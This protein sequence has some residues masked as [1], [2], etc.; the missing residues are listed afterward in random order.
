MPACIKIRKQTATTPFFVGQILNPKIIFFL[1]R[2]EYNFIR[3]KLTLSLFDFVF[4]RKY[5]N[6]YNIA[7]TRPYSLCLH[8]AFIAFCVPGEELAFRSVETCVDP[9]AC[10]AA[11]WR[12]V[13][14]KLVLMVGLF[15]STRLKT[16]PCHI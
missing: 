2:S 7:D 14:L 5:K 4:K 15:V 11:S 1:G 16:S 9:F 12:L 13:P 6:K 3:Q 10:L 8:H